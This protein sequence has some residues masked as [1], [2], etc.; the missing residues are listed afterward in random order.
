MSRPLRCT[1]R[2]LPTLWRTAEAPSTAQLPKG[3]SSNYTGTV[4]QLKPANGTWTYTLVY[5]FTGGDDGG[6]PG[7]IVASGTPNVLYGTAG[8]RAS[9]YGVIFKIT[10]DS[11]G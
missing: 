2:C 10:P 7:S 6:F 3:G 11:S 4:F 1:E 5:A 9:T 8:D